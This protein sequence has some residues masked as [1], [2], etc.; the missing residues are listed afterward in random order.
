M[1]EKEE[2]FGRL[3]T[4]YRLDRLTSGLII[5]AKTSAVAQAWGKVI[6]KR[7]HCE[8]LYLARVK[9]RFPTL[10]PTNVPCLASRDTKPNHGEWETT[11]PNET[12]TSRQKNALGY[13]MED[14]RD[15][16]L[17]DQSIATFAAKT[18]DIEACLADLKTKDP[19]SADIFPWLRL[20]CPVRVA[21][22]KRGICVS[23]E[24]NAVSSVLWSIECLTVSAPWRR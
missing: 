24:T 21:E 6:Q 22:Q 14:S 2:R 16:Q 12:T 18:H 4:I 17:E 20:A 11:S 1:L 23:T 19:S 7:E 13:W 3:Y 5:L 8:K 9:G 15:R 10:C